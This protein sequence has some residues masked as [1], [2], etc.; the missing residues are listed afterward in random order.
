MKVFLGTFW[1]VCVCVNYQLSS[2]SQPGAHPSII[3]FVMFKLGFSQPHFW[4]PPGSSSGSARRGC[5]SVAAGPEKEEGT[6]SSCLL[7]LPMRVTSLPQRQPQFLPRAEAESIFQFFQYSEDQ[8]HRPPEALAQ[9]SS[10]LRGPSAEP[11]PFVPRP[12]AGLLPPLLHLS[13]LS[14]SFTSL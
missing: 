11:L 12:G 3:C 8:L 13:V 9:P 2:V 4:L 6:A 14:L 10:L 5:E 1:G 7:P